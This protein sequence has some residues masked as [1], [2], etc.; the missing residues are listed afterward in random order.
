[1]TQRHCCGLSF[2]LCALLL[3]FRAQDRTRL[4]VRGD[5]LLKRKARSVTLPW[6]LGQV[7]RCL[8]VFYY[9]ITWNSLCAFTDVVKC[10]RRHLSFHTCG[11]SKPRDPHA[12][13]INI[14]M[15]R[16]MD[17]PLARQPRAE[18]ST[19]GPWRSLQRWRRVNHT[20]QKEHSRS[21]ERVVVRGRSCEIGPSLEVHEGASWKRTVKAESAVPSYKR[22]RWSAQSF[23]CCFFLHFLGF[24]GCRKTPRKVRLMTCDV[25][26]LMGAAASPPQHSVK[27]T[28]PGFWS[29]NHPRRGM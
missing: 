17:L 24:P 12:K 9:Y 19:S 11:V 20:Q 28:V 16:P 13:E 3:L 6:L 8:H 5:F 1:M 26:E 27:V 7:V 14:S 25:V 15:L 10:I 22:T 21:R 4:D 2:Q 29:V 18:R 23:F